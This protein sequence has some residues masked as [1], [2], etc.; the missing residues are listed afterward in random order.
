MADG[1]QKDKAGNQNRRSGTQAKPTGRTVKDPPKEGQGRSR[2]AAQGDPAVKGQK[3]GGQGPKK[4]I[5]TRQLTVTIT[6]YDK[7]MDRIIEALQNRIEGTASL[8]AG[9]K[10]EVKN[11]KS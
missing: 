5:V 4:K 6:A 2:A 1:G 3:A 7:Y 11:A 10:V 8:A 9:T